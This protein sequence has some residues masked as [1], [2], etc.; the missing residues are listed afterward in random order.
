MRSRR[1][2]TAMVV[3]T[4]LASL[5]TPAQAAASVQIR[6]QWTFECLN[7]AYPAYANAN[8]RTGT[9]LD[10]GPYWILERVGQVGEIVY[11]RIRREGTNFC[12]VVRGGA[13]NAEG[14]LYTCGSWIDQHWTI[15][16]DRIGY[17][18]SNRNSGK[19]LT[20]RGDGTV[21]VQFTCSD[22]ADQF[23][24]YRAP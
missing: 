16:W 18:F 1:I 3:L 14:V 19:C 8:V 6:N 17:K 9:C 10:V 24:D 20:G 21:V 11:H 13:N 7:T 12:L 23:W 15:Y 22:Y 4:S 5:P 2:A